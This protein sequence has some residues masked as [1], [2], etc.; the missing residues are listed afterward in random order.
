MRVGRG[1]EVGA[2]AVAVSVHVFG[3]F[4]EDRRAGRKRLRLPD[5]L[6]AE[7]V[8]QSAASAL[9]SA[10]HTPRLKHTH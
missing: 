9:M 7:A 5:T 3:V 2:E 4:V 8:H 10:E 6:K 1:A